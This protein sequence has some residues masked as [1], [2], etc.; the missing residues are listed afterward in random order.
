[1]CWEHPALSVGVH[2]VHSSPV[3]VMVPLR[4]AGP[5]SCHS[6][7]PLET[8]A[9][10]VWQSCKTDSS[11][12]QVLESGC[13]G[14][15]HLLFDCVQFSQ[16]GLCCFFSRFISVASSTSQGFG[17]GILDEWEPGS[18]INTQQSSRVIFARGTWI[19][20]EVERLHDW[21]VMSPPSETPVWTASRVSVPCQR[22]EKMGGEWQRN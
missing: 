5:M 10:C 18:S 14:P 13:W 11:H 16:Q 1:M 4:A 15:Q 3:T 17:T 8:H 20:T 19:L 9:H 2:N 7:L 6:G 21:Y 12:T 22:I